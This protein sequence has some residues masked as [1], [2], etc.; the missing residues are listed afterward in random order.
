LGPEPAA[1]FRGGRSSPARDRAQVAAASTRAVRIS[2]DSKHVEYSAK[3]SNEIN[4]LGCFSSGMDD[5]EQTQP[6]LYVP[7]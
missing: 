2:D 6:P 1:V 3:Y 4:L 7:E 5:F